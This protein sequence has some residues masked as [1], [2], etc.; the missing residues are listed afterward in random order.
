MTLTAFLLA[1]LPN[2]RLNLGAE[3]AAFLS[4]LA[5]IIATTVYIIWGGALPPPQYNEFCIKSKI[6]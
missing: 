6:H 2:Q 4:L 3:D 5:R 1:S